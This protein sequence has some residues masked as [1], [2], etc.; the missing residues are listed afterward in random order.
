[1]KQWGLTLRVNPLFLLVSLLFFL[2]GMF[3]DL[4]IAYT[5]VL[6]HEMAH[7]ITAY[8][9]GYRMNN[10]ELFPFGGMAEYSGLLE[11]EPKDE[12]KVAL[13]GPLVNM[14]LFLIFFILL[15][16]DI[17]Y[18]SSQV[19]LILIY[20]L[21]IATVNLIP[22]LPL[23]G[24]RILRSLLV[25]IYGI[26]LGNQIAIKIAKILAILGIITAVF[27]LIFQKANIWFLFF[28]FF[29]YALITKEEK[30]LFY[31]FLRY[32]SQ[33]NSS[34]DNLSIKK[35]S[36]QVVSD[37][38]TIK[39]AIYH[40]NPVKYTMFFVLDVEKR[41]IGTISE[42]TLINQYFQQKHKEMIMRDII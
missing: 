6:I 29:I 38:L 1:M 19:E 11:M 18:M 23:D 27:I 20:N 8:L 32:L 13:A 21:I 40:I 14:G 36:A 4:L 10:I 39:E 7:S 34:I 35:M 25:Q 28:F 9:L 12:I 41:M 3:W 2:V 37:S 5:L 24:G 31:Y 15:N 16:F 42:S 30:Q 17:I 26:K 22:A 33:R